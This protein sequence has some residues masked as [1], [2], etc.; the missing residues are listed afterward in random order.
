MVGLNRRFAPMVS[1]LR[2]SLGEGPKHLLYRV[3]SGAIPTS[4]WLHDAAEGGGMMVGEMCHFLDLMMY[5]ADERPVSAFAESLTLGRA[6]L[7]DSD[8]VTITVRFDGG[9]VGTLVYNTVGDKA[10]PKERLEVYGGGAVAVLDDFRRLET[11]AGGTRSKK[12]AA[13]QDKGQAR[14]MEATIDAFRHGRSPIPFEEL[15]DVMRTVF[16][17][18]RSLATGQSVPVH[19]T[20]PV[21]G[22][23]V[24]SGEASV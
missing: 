23:G 4:T 15:V 5:L 8:N 19:A 14:Q 1:A 22:D 20:A 18:R 13:N 3:N 2:E 7:A 24:S 16:A 12:K 6:D 11:S 17:A 9:S 21:G 10:M